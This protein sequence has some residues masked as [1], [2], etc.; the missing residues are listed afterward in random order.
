MKRSGSALRRSKYNLCDR[1]PR[2]RRA[3]DRTA[4]HHHSAYPFSNLRSR[5]AVEHLSSEPPPSIVLTQ[6]MSPPP[7]V[8]SVGTVAAEGA[9]HD[10]HQAGDG[11]D[12]NGVDE[13]LQQSATTPSDT[14]SSV[15]RGGMG[16]R[17]RA[18]PRFVGEQ[19][20]PHSPHHGDDERLRRRC[21]QPPRSGLNA[22]LDDQRKGR[23]DPPRSSAIR[24]SERTERRRSPPS[25]G[26]APPVTLARSA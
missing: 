25:T 14:G 26:R 5:C 2:A 17:R 22:S 11:A 12:D 18:L 21:R 8:S 24:M 9:G 4:G 15:L 23:Q 16:D 1:R 3:A 7:R 10:D 19:A 20:A 13:R 6:E